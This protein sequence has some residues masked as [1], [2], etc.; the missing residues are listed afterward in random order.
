MF[1]FKGMLLLYV[2][3]CYVGGLDCIE[4]FVVI[5]EIG[6]ISVVVCVVG[7]SYK[8]VWDVIDVMNNFVDELLVSCV[9]GGKCGGG[10]MFMLCG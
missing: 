6:S 9:I 5:G 3:G 8:G 7:M 4:L 10:I 1:E 2:G